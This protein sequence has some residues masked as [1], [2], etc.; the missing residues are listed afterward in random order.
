MTVDVLQIFF[1]S[2]ITF[3]RETNFYV[4][5]LISLWEKDP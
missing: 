4:V 1:K 2:R 5:T 3:G